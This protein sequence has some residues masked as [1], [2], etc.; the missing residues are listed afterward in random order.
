MLS[1]PEAPLGADVSGAT[2]KGE[3]RAVRPS[4]GF[5]QDVY[6]LRSTHYRLNYLPVGTCILAHPVITTKKAVSYASPNKKTRSPTR[7]RVYKQKWGL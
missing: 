3:R 6:H 1:A 2:G 7:D 4:E 5:Y